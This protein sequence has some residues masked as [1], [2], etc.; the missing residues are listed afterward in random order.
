MLFHQ[1]L[2]IRKE[3][4]ENSIK[5][6]FQKYIRKNLKV[7]IKG[8]QIFAHK[9]KCNF[10][11]FQRTPFDEL[12]SFVKS[13]DINNIIYNNTCS[14]SFTTVPQVKVKYIPSTGNFR[15]IRCFSNFC[16]NWLNMFHIKLTLKCRGE[17]VR[18]RGN[19]SRGGQWPPARGE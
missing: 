6:H 4:L 11:N 3:N 10:M 13:R 1:N 7:E 14:D 9:W 5:F 19:N 18:A 12:L 17:A 2:S 8:I 15:T 16:P